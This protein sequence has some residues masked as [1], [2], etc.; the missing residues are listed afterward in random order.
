MLGSIFAAEASLPLAHSAHL[1]STEVESAASAPAHTVRPLD[2]E[3]AV[4]TGSRRASPLDAPSAVSPRGEP[5][6]VGPQVFDQRGSND[7][8]YEPL[9]RGSGFAV[10]VPSRIANRSDEAPEERSQTRDRQGL[11]VA[12]QPLIDR[13]SAAASCVGL[14]ETAVSHNARLAADARN[15]GDRRG[16]AMRHEP[17]EIQIHIG[18]IEVAAISQPA[19]R[20]ASRAGVTRSL[21]LDEYL[22][23]GNGRSG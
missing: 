20:P 16:A 2:A 3:V 8:T 15:R 4:L 7:E 23:R 17:N 9:V 11:P 14:S 6:P 22:R 13:G 18:R 5:S 12:I 10:D 21:N 1:M 19:P